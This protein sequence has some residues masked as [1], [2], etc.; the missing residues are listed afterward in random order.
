MV[1]ENS[2]AVIIAKLSNTIRQ[3]FAQSGLSG[4][5]YWNAKPVL[6]AM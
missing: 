2:S 3:V 4:Q 6:T 5:K 1:V